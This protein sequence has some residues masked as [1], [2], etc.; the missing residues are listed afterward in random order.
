MTSSLTFLFY[1]RIAALCAPFTR[2]IF[3]VIKM[4]VTSWKALGFAWRSR[5]ILC[6]LQ[7]ILSPIV[8]ISVERNFDGW[9]GLL[10]K[11]ETRIFSEKEASVL[12]QDPKTQKVPKKAIN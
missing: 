5:K 10:K 3:D 6:G 1:E 12:K 4:S 11:S 9:C 7:S 8:F 2:F